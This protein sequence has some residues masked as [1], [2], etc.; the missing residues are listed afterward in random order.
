MELFLPVNRSFPYH[1]VP[2]TSG[3][4]KI[5]AQACGAGFMKCHQSSVSVC[6]LSVSHMQFFRI[7]IWFSVET[8]LLS[9]PL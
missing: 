5:D 3:S 8:L 9:T 7:S 6:Q 1:T 4:H 2:V